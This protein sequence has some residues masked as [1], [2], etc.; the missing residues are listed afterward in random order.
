V[1]T[2]IGIRLVPIGKP[3]THE[4][5]SAGDTLGAA[6]VPSRQGTME[7]TADSTRVTFVSQGSPVNVG[8]DAPP[9]IRLVNASAANQTALLRALARAGTPAGSADQPIAFVFDTDKSAAALEGLQ[10]IR[11]PWML[12]TVLRFQSG[13]PK[14]VHVRTGANKQELVIGVGA[15]ASSFAAASIVRDVLGARRSIDEYAEEEIARTADATLNAWNRQPAAVDR[16]AWRTA[17]T[18][19]ARWCWLIVLILL[20][21][22]Q[23]LRARQPGR[24]S[25]H[26]VTRVAA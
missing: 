20:G 14:L 4:N 1:P 7:L 13:D 21:L 18:T 16:E 24:R 15:P 22:E 26:E 23:W 11:E 25:Q 12:R 8:A 10:P 6:G 2:S 5:V 17:S 9:G 3:V 19:D